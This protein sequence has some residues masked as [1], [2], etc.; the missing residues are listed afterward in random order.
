[1]IFHFSGTNINDQFLPLLSEL[2]RRDNCCERSQT[3]R[4][5]H[6]TTLSQATNREN[7]LVFL[8]SGERTAKERFPAHR[9]VAPPEG[10][11]QWF[12]TLA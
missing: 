2:L 9:T 3:T 11:S 6:T 7:T 1:M 10:V 12:P 8:L 4:Y 5:T